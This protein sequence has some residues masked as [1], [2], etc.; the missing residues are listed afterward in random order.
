MRF[1]CLFVINHKNNDLAAVQRVAIF[2]MKGR[3][4]L[5]ARILHCD[6]SDC[7]GFFICRKQTRHRIN[8]SNR[9]WHTIPTSNKPYSH[10]AEYRS[11]TI[12][13]TGFSLPLV[14]APKH[15]ENFISDCIYPF[16]DLSQFC[17]KQEII[18]F[19]STYI[20]VI[21]HNFTHSFK[22]L[23]QKR[24]SRHS[25]FQAILPVIQ[26]RGQNRRSELC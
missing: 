25:F 5:Y 22:I 14:S 16:C 8:L 26:I 2:A 6:R 7:S 13:Q 12:F 23:R 10:H 20:F 17:K 24:R 19:T 15:T 21:N 18:W 11:V 9:K 1:F 4:L 3:E